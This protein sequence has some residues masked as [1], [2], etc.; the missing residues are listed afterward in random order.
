MRSTAAR[1][2]PRRAP[3]APPPEP[4]FEIVAPPGWRPSQ[5]AIAALARLLLDRARRELAE[6]QQAP[7]REPAAGA[8]E[9]RA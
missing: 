6:R 1:R 7:A 9:V 3:A 5:A 2:T 8:T 4:V